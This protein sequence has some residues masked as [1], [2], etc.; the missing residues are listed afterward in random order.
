MGSGICV[1]TDAILVFFRVKKFACHCE[2]G[3]YGSKENLGWFCWFRF[4]QVG[5]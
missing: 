5:I 2:D 1:Q 3:V 4:V